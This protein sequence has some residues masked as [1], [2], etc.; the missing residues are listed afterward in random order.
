MQDGWWVFLERLKQFPAWGGP[1]WVPDDSDILHSRIRTTGFNTQ[2]FNLNGIS[3]HL[4]DV[5]GQR[6]ERKKW[7]HLFNGITGVI[8]V[9]SLSEYDQ[10]LFEDRS[11]NRLDE[12]IRL[13][14]KTVREKPFRRTA[15][16]LFL[17]KFDLFQKKFYDQKIPIEYKGGRSPPTP[18]QEEDRNC[19]KA[20]KWYQELYLE[21]CP[22]DRK[23]SVFI[24][25]TTALDKRNMK[26]VM[27]SV[28]TYILQEKMSATSH[29]SLPV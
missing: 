27:N 23:E 8:F 3:F 5:G 12:S 11:T 19:A 16:V 25:I 26:K 7:M 20:I 4:T 13:W 2:E 21:H 22:A 29:D 6:N 28:A 9:S 17:N 24:H 14:H 18:D 1:N 15:A 10:K